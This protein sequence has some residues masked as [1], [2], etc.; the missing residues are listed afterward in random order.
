MGLQFQLTQVLASIDNPV[1]KHGLLASQHFS[2]DFYFYGSSGV[3]Q[4]W[5]QSGVSGNIP[6]VVSCL[7][8]QKLM[9]GAVC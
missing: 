3:L 9:I 1:E 8:A 2:N 5:H 7:Q 4:K 6:E